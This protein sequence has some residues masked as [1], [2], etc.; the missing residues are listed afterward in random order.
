MNV[1]INPEQVDLDWTFIVH[2][3]SNDLFFFYINR[4]NFASL[5][6][7]KISPSFLK[8]GDLSKI[9]SWGGGGDTPVPLPRINP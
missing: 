8:L 2:L 1:Q 3:S 4:N 5:S 6:D 9:W 7:V